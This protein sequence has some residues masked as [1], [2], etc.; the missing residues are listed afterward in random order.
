MKTLKEIYCYPGLL[1]FE[2]N[3]ENA[4]RMMASL[5]E[6]GVTHVQINH[7][8]DL[9]HPEQL[10]Q[11][12]NVYLAFAN[13]GPPLD[14]YVSSQYN[15]GLWPEMYLDRNLACLKRFAAAARK[16]GIK[17][18]LYLCEPRFVPERFFQKNP[19]LRGP[20]VDNPT[21]S[22]TPLF[23]LCTDMPEVKAHYREMMGK[24]LELVPDLA[25]VSIFTSDSGSGFDYNPHS[26]AGS[27]G[28]AFNRGIPLEKRVS[29]FLALLLEEGRKKSPDFEVHLT[30]GFDP[31]M[32]AKILS[33]A[34]RGVVGS[35]NGLYDWEGGLEEQW[36]Y[37]QAM[38]APGG[39]KWNIRNLDRKSAYAERFADMKQR[40]AASAT[41]GDEPLVHAELPTTDYPRPLRY[42]PQ[43]F[44][45][46][47]I[48]KAYAE[49]GV[50]R[51]TAWGVMSPRELVPHD[52]NAAA[53]RDINENI[54]AEPDALV[55][56]IAVSWVGEKYADVLLKAW[57][58]CDF[59]HCRRPNWAL[60]INKI[61]FPG[62]LVPDLT[63]LKPDEMSYYKTIALA[64]LERIQGLGS[65]IP[66]EADEQDRDF[67]LNE[68]YEKETLPGLDHAASLLEK[69]AASATPAVSAVLRQQ[70][71][72]IRFAWLFQ[73]TNRNWYE[74]GQHLVQ[75]V[76][77]KP[78]R[79]FGAIVDDEITVTREMI[80]LLDGRV[81]RFI[82]SY[83]S[84][85]MTYEFGDGLVG[86]LQARIRVMQRHRDDTPLPLGDR[87]EKVKAHLAALAK[88][89]E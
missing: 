14:L 3:E 56:G 53:F 41:K 82:R 13:F 85:N 80:T 39:P 11:P 60:G 51:L 89:V 88:Q 52:V 63:A 79:A 33:I 45:V 26:Y 44:E 20:R 77:A 55:R 28:A 34:P 54:S 37:H 17:P 57:Q 67:V 46:I 32:R 66:F 9:M 43:P 8:P 87:L 47:R 31:E 78:R 5:A 69:A 15:H 83:P 23:A 10:A 81:A 42:T 7:L 4:N 65:F 18:I 76:G 16:H 12:G 74:A 27:N 71:E 61:L 72:H 48:M 84:D 30:S 73:R 70:A 2:T 86:Q 22:T 19:T 24:I 40:I 64:D 29:N 36:A 38:W 75:G 21:C 25:A 58:E 68:I 62:P 6:A 35:V 50:K 1:P 49:L 59:A